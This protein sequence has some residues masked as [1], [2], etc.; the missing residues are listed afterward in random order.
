[1]NSAVFISKIKNPEAERI[2]C[3]IKEAE[4]RLQN[5]VNELEIRVG[6][7]EIGENS[8][9][10]TVSEE[11]FHK[12]REEMSECTEKIWNGYEKLRE[13]SLVKIY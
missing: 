13:L 2:L 5:L 4:V 8:I 6:E 10:I 3:I 12:I 1:M 9:A 11:K 7:L